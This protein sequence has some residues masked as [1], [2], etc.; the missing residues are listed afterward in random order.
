MHESAKTCN[1]CSSY[2]YGPVAKLT[3]IAILAALLIRIT[4][5]TLIITA[6]NLRF[7]EMVVS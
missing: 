7:P 2:S 4:I 5:S 3:V 6:P 1:D